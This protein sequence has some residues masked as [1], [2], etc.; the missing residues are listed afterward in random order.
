V[1]KLRRATSPPPTKKQHNRAHSLIAC[2]HRGRKKK[3]ARAGGPNLIMNIGE[4]AKRLKRFDI[5]RLIM[6]ADAADAF[7]T[8]HAIRAWHN[9]REAGFWNALILLLLQ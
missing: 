9:Y 7:L 8:A 4:E 5:F 1:K 3:M 2:W 6:L